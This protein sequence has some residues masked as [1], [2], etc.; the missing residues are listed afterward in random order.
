MQTAND[1]HFRAM[2]TPHRSLPQRGFLALMVLLAVLW[3]GAGLYF[4]SLGAWPVFGF[5]GLDFILIWWLFSRNYK[6]GF[7]CEEVSITRQELILQKTS[8]RGE[9]SVYS[10]NPFW[11]KFYI[12]K[13]E[14]VGIVKMELASKSER[15][16]LGGFLNPDDR[17]SFAKA[18]T[19]ALATAKRS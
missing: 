10:F 18:F 2:L 11:T 12:A 3:G 16:S 15:V 6:E 5:F 9:E 14:G 17:E 13:S 4:M 8:P 19:L 7:A 1:F